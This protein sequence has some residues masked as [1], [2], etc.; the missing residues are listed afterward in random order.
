MKSFLSSEFNRYITATDRLNSMLLTSTKRVIELEAKNE[1][2]EQQLKEA[3]E[4]IEYVVIKSVMHKCDKVILRKYL[5]KYK[6]KD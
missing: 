5:T 2:L 6:I 1:Q 4:L 3:S